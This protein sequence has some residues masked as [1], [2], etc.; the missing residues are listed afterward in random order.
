MRLIRA[1]LIAFSTYSRLPLPRAEFREKDMPFVFCFFPLVG[2]FVGLL[3]WGWS[4]LTETT[5]FTGLLRAAGFTLIPLLATGGIHMDGFLDAS[6]AMASWQPR[7]KKLDIMKDPHMGAFSVIRG[8]M[9]LL[10]MLALYSEIETTHQSLAIGVG[11][12]LSRSLTNVMLICLPNAR[13]SGMVQQFQ[14]VQHRKAVMM[15]AIAFILISLLLGYMAEGWVMLLSAAAMGGTTM[16][17]YCMAKRQ[18]GGITGDLAGYLIQMNELAYA[19][20][21]ILLGG[22]RWS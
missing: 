18:F 10:I 4:L 15:S 12:I 5:R 20:G 8:G 21:V 14:Q 2:A 11:F 13:G 3:F 6:D 22:I 1:L 9:Y 19:A 16:W 17:F 7:E